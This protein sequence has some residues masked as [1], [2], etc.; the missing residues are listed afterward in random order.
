MVDENNKAVEGRQAMS[1]TTTF[2]LCHGSGDPGLFV[3]GYVMAM[4]PLSVAVGFIYGLVRLIKEI[5][6]AK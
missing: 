2:L 6:A 4:A 1:S 3:L 5:H